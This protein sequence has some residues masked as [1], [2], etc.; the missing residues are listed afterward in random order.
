M[1]KQPAGNIEQKAKVKT[2]RHVK[3][4]PVNQCTYIVKAKPGATN[5]NSFR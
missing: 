2:R 4:I 1:K 3:R 5:E